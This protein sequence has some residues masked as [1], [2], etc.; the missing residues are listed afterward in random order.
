MRWK[1]FHG[2][3]SMTCA[4]SVLPEFIG[5]SDPENLAGYRK[6]VFAV[7][8]GDSLKSPVTRA[9]TRFAHDEPQVNRTVVF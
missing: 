7:Q 5:A 1:V 9:N 8:I 6:Q 4:N 3:K 2:R